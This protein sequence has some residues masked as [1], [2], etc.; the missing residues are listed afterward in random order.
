[1]SIKKLDDSCKELCDK[2]EVEEISTTAG[3][4]GYETPY[5]F[6]D[7]DNDDPKKLGE[8][9]YKNI[10]GEIY[11]L[12]YN[13]YKKDE[14]LNTKQKVNGAISEIS[15]KLFQIE[16]ILGRNLKLKKEQGLESSSYWK[17]TKGKLGKIS[18]RMNRIAVKM[19]D[20][21]A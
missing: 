21:S 13:S 3:A 14:S 10:M 19:R 2:D 5:A 8:T 1:M 12:N 20:L 4:P 11:N 16:R 9:K 15:K 18:E 17:S 6:S 7:E